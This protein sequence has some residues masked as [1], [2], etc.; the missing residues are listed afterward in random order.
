MDWECDWVA[1]KREWA[2]VTA[3]RCVT[4]NAEVVRTESVG[5]DI[6]WVLDRCV[7][8]CC[9]LLA[10]EQ[11]RMVLEADVCER[12]STES[13]NCEIDVCDEDLCLD[14]SLWQLLLGRKDAAMN[15]FHCGRMQCSMWAM[16]AMEVA[17]R[18]MSMQ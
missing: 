17:V 6:A 2:C 14:S 8:T 1:E 13:E 4:L 7:R 5:H 12:L 11:T 10:W 3:I 15:S 16:W 9:R 18:Q